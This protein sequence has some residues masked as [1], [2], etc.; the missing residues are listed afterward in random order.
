MLGPLDT[1]EECQGKIPTLELQFFFNNFY[2]TSV[3]QGRC[4][5]HLFTFSLILL[6][7]LSSHYAVMYCHLLTTADNL[8]C[9]MLHYNTAFQ[10]H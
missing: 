6:P 7:T 5:N 4:I 10:R 3:G 9:I 2:Y 1:T 8:F